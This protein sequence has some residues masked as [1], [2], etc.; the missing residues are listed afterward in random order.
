M[1]LSGEHL[2]RNGKRELI[3]GTWTPMPDGRVRQ[4]LEQSR[5]EGESWYVWFDGVYVRRVAE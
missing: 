1:R 2:Y 5:D 4:L 3:R